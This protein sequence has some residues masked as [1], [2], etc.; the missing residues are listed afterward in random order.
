MWARVS[1]QL[2]QLCQQLLILLLLLPCLLTLSYRFSAEYN[3]ISQRAE[4]PLG[5]GSQWSSGGTAATAGYLSA[6]HV[7]C[8]AWQAQRHPVQVRRR[9]ANDFHPRIFKTNQSMIPHSVAARP[10]RRMTAS[11]WA[12]NRTLIATTTTRCS[13]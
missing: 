13:G 6:G 11:S 10:C 8:G 4:V 7:Q 2:R 12:G 9:Y 1:R 3:A 5:R